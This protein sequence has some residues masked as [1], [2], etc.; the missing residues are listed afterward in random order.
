MND[1][2][3]RLRGKD[4]LGIADLTAAEISLILDTAESFVGLELGTGQQMA[5]GHALHRLQY[6][7]ARQEEIAIDER[8]AGVPGRRHRLCT[9]RRGRRGVVDREGAQVDVRAADA[10]A[11]D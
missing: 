4:L 5:R 9:V 1:K 11:P 10:L 7:A 3:V 8:F 2:A 6:R